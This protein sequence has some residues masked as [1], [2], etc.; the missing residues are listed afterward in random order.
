MYRKCSCCG[1]KIGFVYFIR[2]INFYKENDVLKARIVCKFCNLTNDVTNLNSNAYIPAIVVQAILLVIYAN[3]LFE[4]FDDFPVLFWLFSLLPFMV[5]IYLTIMYI[6]YM[7][8]EYE[9]KNIS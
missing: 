2:H 1:K 5:I 4:N 8:F 9:C 7:V 6:L 3:L